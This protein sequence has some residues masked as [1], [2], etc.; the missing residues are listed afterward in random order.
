MATVFLYLSQH[1]DN[2]FYPPLTDVRAQY[3]SDYQQLREV[4]TNDINNNWRNSK[5]LLALLNNGLNVL[6]DEWICCWCEV[7]V[8]TACSKCSSTCNIS[9]PSL[10]SKQSSSVSWDKPCN[11]AYYGEIPL[12][13]KT[14]VRKVDQLSQSL[15]CSMRSLFWDKCTTGQRIM[16]MFAASVLPAPQH[17]YSHPTQWSTIDDHAFPAAAS[18]TWNSLPALPSI[19]SYCTFTEQLTWTAED[20]SGQ[21]EF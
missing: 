8:T 15:Q 10:E 3:V 20:I 11:T 16:S 13:I 9:S 18:Q 1:T 21:T 4:L 12:H 19:G 2:E 5:K 14:K 17:S 6:L 7:T